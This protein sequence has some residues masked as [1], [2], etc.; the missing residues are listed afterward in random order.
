MEYLLFT[1]NKGLIMEHIYLKKQ[2]SNSENTLNQKTKDEIRNLIS[3][4]ENFKK[5]KKIG[6]IIL[7]SLI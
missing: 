1:N 7:H 3:K 5:S 2:N 6:N 4:I